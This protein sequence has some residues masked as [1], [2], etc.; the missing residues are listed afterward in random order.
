[1]TFRICK[2]HHTTA[3]F[4]LEQYA[5]YKDIENFYSKKYTCKH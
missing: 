1:M 4:F 2:M 3:G 5:T